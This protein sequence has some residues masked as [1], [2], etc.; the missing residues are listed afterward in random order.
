MTLIAK[1]KVTK[2][3]VLDTGSVVYDHFQVDSDAQNG[4]VT[5]RIST[6][7][8][9]QATPPA[10]LGRMTVE[11]NNA[12]YVGVG[13]GYLAPVKGYSPE[14]TGPIPSGPVVSANKAVRGY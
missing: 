1:E 7:S 2:K 6:L 10:D 12:S 3:V 8:V 11:S 14:F 13:A 4:T 9:N 5:A